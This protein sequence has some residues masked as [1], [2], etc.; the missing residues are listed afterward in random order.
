MEGCHLFLSPL[1]VMQTEIFRISPSAVVEVFF[2]LQRWRPD[3]FVGCYRSPFGT[4]LVG[5]VPLPP[6]GFC[7]DA[8]MLLVL[9]GL[10]TGAPFPG[11][12]HELVWQL[13]VLAWLSSALLFPWNF[14]CT[15]WQLLVCVQLQGALPSA[16]GFR[17]T[18][19]LFG[20]FSCFWK[21]PP[22]L[23]FP[24]F[25]HQRL[26]LLFLSSFCLN[27]I[28]VTKFPAT[29]ARRSH[30]N[31][32][33]T[34]TDKQT[35][36]SKARPCAP[37]CSSPVPPDIATDKQTCTSKARPCAPNC[38]SPVPPG[39]RHRQTNL[40]L[41]SS[42]LRASQE[43][44]VPNISPLTRGN[45]MNLKTL[46]NY[47]YFNT[48][49]TM[50]SWLR[51]EEHPS[52]GG[53][54]TSICLEQRVY[55][56]KFSSSC[57]RKSPPFLPLRSYNFRWFRAHSLKCVKKEPCALPVFSIRP[58]WSSLEQGKKLQLF[59]SGG[60]AKFTSF[61]FWTGSGVRWIGQIAPMQIHVEWEKNWMYTTTI[62][63]YHRNLVR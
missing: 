61:M 51:E 29:F 4:G 60:V 15:V 62:P 55:N 63:P 42:A 25:F 16:R 18:A 58:A 56:F 36:T 33:K 13:P 27:F 54:S 39:Y 14:R 46:S 7:S 41:E 43:T 20:H 26:F 38:S 30:K 17:W 28:K 19:A 2:R 9:V 22:V 21:G 6:A 47:I 5:W 1:F 8:S 24:T 52:E 31:R 44:R 34:A 11:W 3:D 32:A 35:C 48:N 10:S 49:V 23:P 45:H 57:P 50:V 12:F 37:H 40:Y 53:G 59:L